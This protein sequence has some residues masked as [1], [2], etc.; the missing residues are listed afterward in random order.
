MM[1]GTSADGIDAAL[2][3]FSALSAGEP[4]GHWHYS[5]PPELQ[6]RLFRLQESDA[7]RPL[8]AIDREIGRLHGEFAQ[9]I[10]SAGVQFDLLALHGQTVAHQPNGPDGYTWQVGSA[11]DVAQATGCTVAHDFRRADVAAGGQGAPL[12]PPFHEARLATDRPL[13]VLNLGGMANLTWVPA[14]GSR[15]ATRAFD[16]G[17]GNV[18]IDAAVQV[19][20]RGELRYDANGDWAGQGQVQENVVQEWLA[21]D[22]FHRPPPKSTGRE[23]FNARWVEAQWSAWQH[24]KA[25]FLASLCALTATSIAQAAQRWL[26]PAARMLVFGGGAYNRTLL[27]SLQT[28]LPDVAVEMGEQVSGIPSAAMEALAFAW[29]G[30]QCLLGRTIDLHGVTGQREAVVLGSLYPGKNWSQLLSL[31]AQLC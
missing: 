17:P 27:S 18:L 8:L 10:R 22:Y 1:S 26:P 16:S 29:L 7:A 2:L 15:Q 9:Q 21:L 19:L 30:G 13:L 14:R 5:Y 23:L 12:V 24:G 3:E 20:S 31:R 28:A 4:R 11:Y 6:E 25:D